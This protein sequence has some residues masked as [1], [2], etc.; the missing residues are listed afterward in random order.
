MELND[1]TQADPSTRARILARFREWLDEA[2]SHEEPPPG[3]AAEIL[4]EIEGEA[5]PEDPTD[6][7]ALRAAMTA[8]V[9]E[10]GLQGRSFHQLKDVL[11]PVSEMGP[12]IDEALEAYERGLEE[13]R[14]VRDEALALREEWQREAV[15]EASRMAWRAVI[16][17]LLDMRDR[18]GRGIETALA[19]I[20]ARPAPAP[21]GWWDRLLG[22]VSPPATEAAEAIVEGCR[23][24]LARLDDALAEI[25]VSEIP[26]EGRPF[27]PQRM[28]AVEIGPAE[29]ATEGQVLA[30]R[31]RGYVWNG[32]L[33]RHAEVRVARGGA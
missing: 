30:V 24:A 5:P 6:F 9:Q 19:S 10:V 11:R 23:L 12:R 13:M 20:A 1:P 31:R 3:I 14:R 16:D 33:Y 7:H 26:C 8:L 15:R 27:D 21:P 25:G 18:L 29:G 2:L 28:K 32:E 22:R 17:L 4:A